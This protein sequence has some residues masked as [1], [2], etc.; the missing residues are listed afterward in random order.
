MAFATRTAIPARRTKP[1]GTPTTRGGGRY[2]CSMAMAPTAIAGTRQ[3]YPTGTVPPYQQGRRRLQHRT[4]TPAA[5][6][7]YQ[8]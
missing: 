3:C 2:P 8:D 6:D 4:T 5:P 7:Y 1:Q